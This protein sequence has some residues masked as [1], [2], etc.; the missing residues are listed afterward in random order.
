MNSAETYDQCFGRVVSEGR[1]RPRPNSC[2]KSRGTTRSSA[3]PRAPR[4]FHLKAGA[5]VP[6]PG[7]AGWRRPRARSQSPAFNAAPAPLCPGPGPALQR[8]APRRG[9]PLREAVEW[10]PWGSARSSFPL[11][12]FSE[13]LDSV[14]QALQELSREEKLRVLGLRGRSLVSVCAEQTEPGLLSVSGQKQRGQ[15]GAQEVPP[16]TR[17]LR[18]AVQVMHPAR[19]LRA[20]G[21]PRYEIASCHPWYGTQAASEAPLLLSFCTLPSFT[22]ISDLCVHSKYFPIVFYLRFSHKSRN[23]PL[24]ARQPFPCCLQA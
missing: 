23:Q 19:G 21:C 15:R 11:F 2:T 18:G 20:V 12:F 22:S 3:R 13:L 5:A 14:I 6:Q 10:K 7:P 24:E 9:R 17:Q 8:A 1:N 16:S 4:Q